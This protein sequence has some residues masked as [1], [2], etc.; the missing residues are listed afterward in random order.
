MMDVLLNCGR[1][2]NPAA[3]VDISTEAQISNI[4]KSFNKVNE[5]F[6][7]SKLECPGKPHLKA[8][9]SWE[10]FPDTEIWANAYDLFKFSERPGDRPIEVCAFPQVKFGLLIVAARGR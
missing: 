10:V 7:L 9:D 1:K 3:S 2:I 5:D 4:E 6:D 8:L